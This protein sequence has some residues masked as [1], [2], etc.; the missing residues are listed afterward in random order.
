MKKRILTLLLT[1]ILG[2]GTS[3]IAQDVVF[4]K[5]SPSAVVKQGFATSFIELNYS[6]PST[7]GRAVFGD[8]VPFDEIWRTGANS[9]T[10]IEFGQNVKINGK[11]IMKGKYGLLSIPN[12]ENWTIILTKDLNVTSANAYKKENDVVRIEAKTNALSQNV[13]TFTIEVSNISENKSSIE[14]KWEKV[15]VSFDVNAEFENELIAQI[16]KTMSTDNRPYYAS[17]QYYYSN[18]K[19]MAKALEWIRMADKQS[20]G[21]YWIENLKAKIEF[22]NKLYV[23]AIETAKNAKENATKAGNAAYAKQMEELIQSIENNPEIKLP[24]K[25]K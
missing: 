25:K 17:A 2:A 16:E 3:V 13:E 21:R 1:G 23:E 24:K 11:E 22:E 15:S 18:K 12:K 9:A 20:P 19:D 5:P 14:I 10:T 4:P 6:R 8:L 7:K